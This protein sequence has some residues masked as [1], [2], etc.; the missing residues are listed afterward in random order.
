MLI[1]LKRQKQLTVSAIMHDE[2]I[3]KL[4]TIGFKTFLDCAFYS[5]LFDKLRRVPTATDSPQKFDLRNSIHTCDF[6]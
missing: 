4:Y 3:I 5:Y 2:V 6:M 1:E